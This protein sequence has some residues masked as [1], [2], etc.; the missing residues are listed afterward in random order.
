M[1]GRPCSLFRASNRNPPSPT[2]RGS[3]DSTDRGTAPVKQDAAEGVPELARADLNARVPAAP[4][5][6]V[7]RY[8]CDGGP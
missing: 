5:P 6:R 4:L 7:C 2:H 8:G 3:E 1:L